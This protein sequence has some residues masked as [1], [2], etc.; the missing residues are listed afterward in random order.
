[1]KKLD[2]KAA[3]FDLNA[4]QLRELTPDEA[5]AASGGITSYICRGG[6]SAGSGIST[7]L[8]YNPAPPVYVDYSTTWG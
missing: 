3:K 4:K 7:W 1:M 6:T 8:V 5:E 2:L